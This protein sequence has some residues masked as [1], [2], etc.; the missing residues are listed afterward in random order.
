MLLRLPLGSGTDRRRRGR[1]AADGPE[2]R[3]ATMF[4]GVAVNEMRPCRKRNSCGH[5]SDF[6]SPV[7]ETAVLAFSS[8][9]R[10]LLQIQYKS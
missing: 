5:S 3:P 6:R 10:S 2:S 9:I 1:G 7:A 8:V 4:C